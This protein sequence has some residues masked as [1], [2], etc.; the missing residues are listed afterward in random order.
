MCVCFQFVFAWMFE[1]FRPLAGVS[2][3]EACEF[4]PE[5]TS[6]SKAR[7]RLLSVVAL[8]FSP[9]ASD[10]LQKKQEGHGELGYIEM[11]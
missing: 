4:D 2:E 7:Q 1:G 6:F 10:G 5:E 9:T 8:P 11:L 3:D